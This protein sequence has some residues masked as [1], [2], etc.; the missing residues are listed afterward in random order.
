MN[1]ADKLHYDQLAG[2]AISLH[3]AKH[4]KQQELYYRKS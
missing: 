1:I 4:S 3:L 2:R